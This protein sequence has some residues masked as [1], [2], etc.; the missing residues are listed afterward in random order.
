M[1]L[2]G[3]ENFGVWKGGIGKKR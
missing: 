3:I 2:G 1:A